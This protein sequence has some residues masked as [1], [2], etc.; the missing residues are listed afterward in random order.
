MRTWTLALLLLLPGSCD[1]PDTGSA[2]PVEASAGRA[3][4]AA[5]RVQFGLVA[6]PEL[7][8]GAPTADYPH[9]DA[10]GTWVVP[11][12]AIW[13]LEQPLLSCRVATARRSI[14]ALG[15]P[16][17]DVALQGEDGARFGE[18]TRRAVGRRLAVLVDGRVV[19]TP[20]VAE[21]L[22]P[23]FQLGGR[24]SEEDVRKLLGHLRAPAGD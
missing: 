1:A 20:T 10:D 14:D 24:F 17:V 21:A 2:D 22:P 6:D 7:A 12:E 9:W 19:L 16:A 13:S 8:P 18:L 3:D 15:F 23:R 4:V 11:R 5:G